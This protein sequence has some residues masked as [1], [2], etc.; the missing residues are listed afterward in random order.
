MFKQPFFEA[1]SRQYASLAL[2]YMRGMGTEEESML[3]LS[4]QLFTTRSLVVLGCGFPWSTLDD[5]GAAVEVS[6]SESMPDVLA[7][8]LS[9]LC[10]AIEGCCAENKT[11]ADADSK[12][13]EH[14]CLYSC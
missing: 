9:A 13:F 8:L 14:R 5:G 7:A 1:F 2:L 3:S 11:F 6:P 4:V 12:C 10:N